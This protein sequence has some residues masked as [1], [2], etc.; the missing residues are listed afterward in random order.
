M[1]GRFV[2]IGGSRISRRVPAL[3]KVQYPGSSRRPPLTPFPSFQRPHEDSGYT[4]LLPLTATH[5]TFTEDN[6]HG[7]IQQRLAI[8]LQPLA[9]YA[10]N[11]PFSPA[12]SD[13]LPPP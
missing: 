5:A 4:S 1:A 3:C 7:W 6:P 2:P 13:G 11:M 12:I 9:S 10:R 8:P